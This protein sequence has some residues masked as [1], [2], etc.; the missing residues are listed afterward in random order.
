M[1][2]GDTLAQGQIHKRCE[3]LFDETCL[4]GEKE[5]KNEKMKGQI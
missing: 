4:L 5:K 3:V 1:K 2:L